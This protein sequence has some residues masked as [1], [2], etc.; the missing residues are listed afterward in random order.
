MATISDDLT[1]ILVNRQSSI[2]IEQSSKVLGIDF[3][4]TMPRWVKDL[5]QNNLYILLCRVMLLAW[6]QS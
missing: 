5:S 4:T 2:R 1:E 3:D 6:R